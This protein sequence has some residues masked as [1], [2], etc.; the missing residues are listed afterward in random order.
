MQDNL[1]SG[2]LD[3]SAILTM[4]KGQSYCKYTFNNDQIIISL[5]RNLFRD[6]VKLTAQFVAKNGKS[7]LQSLIQKEQRNFMFDFLRPQHGFF[8]YF[9]KLV[10]QYSKVRTP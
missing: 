1:E 5:T 8:Q 2:A 4:F 9:T 6:V 7:F 3:H 10:E